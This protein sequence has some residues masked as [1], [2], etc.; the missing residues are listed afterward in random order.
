M[1]VFLADVNTVENTKVN[2]VIRQACLSIGPEQESTPRAYRWLGSQST[3]PVILERLS[4]FPFLHTDKVVPEKRFEEMGYA[5][6]QSVCCNL[7]FSI[8]ITL[9]P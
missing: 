9:I 4:M 3:P 6:H 7:F 2:S 8:D 5:K 1:S